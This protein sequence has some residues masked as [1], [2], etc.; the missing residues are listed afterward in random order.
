MHLF[1]PSH[2]TWSPHELLAGSALETLHLHKLQRQLRYVAERSP[3]YRAKFAAAGVL[4][5]DVTTL[6]D[7]A[8][9]PFTEKDE[10]RASLEADPPLGGHLCAPLGTIVQRQA[11]SGTTGKPSYFAYTR[12]DLAI[13]CEMT[14]RCFYAAG[15][16]PGDGILHAF[17]MSRG[18]VGGLPMAQALIHLGA[19]LLPLGAETGAPRLLQTMA[20]QRPV[21]IVGAPSFIGYLG[22]QAQDV[23]GIPAAELGVRHIL[24]GSEP[25][26]GQPETRGRLERLWNAT[27][28]EMYGMS[29]LGNSFWSESL[30][31]EGM[32]FRGQGFVHWELIDPATGAVL[33]PEKGATGELVYT[34]ID[35]EAMPLIR[36]RSRDHVAIVETAPA[37]GQTG[38]RIRVLGRTDDMLI[39]RGINVYPS[40]I[41]DILHSMRPTTTGRF[42]II[43]DF[44][45]SATERPLRIVTEIASPDDGTAGEVARVIHDRLG[46]RTLIEAVPPGT[47][48]EPGAR[49]P[50]LVERTAPPGATAA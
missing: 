9:L 36:F 4:P 41:Q 12:R 28:R 21:G 45:G 48:P 2:P 34:A 47:L 13:V 33:P 42:K 5:E 16:R 7:L 30:E 8:R 49:K 29:D 39:C 14:A 37:A 32:F 15:F 25:G 19:S 23:L 11:S 35:R 27:V 17:A 50:V 26:G 24:V 44:A 1:S 20:D 22:E 38:P 43:A 3:L 40:A 18:F 31:A 6:A 46:V 10:I